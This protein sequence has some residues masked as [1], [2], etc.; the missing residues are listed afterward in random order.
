MV[1]PCFYHPFPGTA[2]T[3]SGGCTQ[4]P[5]TMLW[6]YSPQPVPP[7]EHNLLQMVP[8]YTTC[9]VE[10][11]GETTTKVVMPPYCLKHNP[12]CIYTDRSSEEQFTFR[13][14]FSGDQQA[15]LWCFP[16]YPKWVVCCRSHQG[17]FSQV[18]SIRTCK[19][20]TYLLQV[21]GGGCLVK[22]Q[23]GQTFLPPQL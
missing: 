14:L 9:M 10:G 3:P 23:L 1:E 21:W 12:T 20:H 4:T 6:N 18:Q 7:T 17:S 8:L 15:E 19:H 2:K 11:G 22:T 16:I 5:D 13:S